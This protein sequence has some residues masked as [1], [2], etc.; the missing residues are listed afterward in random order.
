MNKI[1]GIN[2]RCKDVEEKVFKKDSIHK[3]QRNIVGDNIAEE[4]RKNYVQTQNV[5][6][7]NVKKEQENISKEYGEIISEYE[8]LI[9]GLKK[10]LQKEE[11]TKSEAEEKLEELN[12]NIENKIKSID[13]RIKA[14]NEM[15]KSI[16]DGIKANNEMKKNAE[17]YKAIIEKEIERLEKEKLISSQEHKGKIQNQESI[18]EFSNRMIEYYNASIKKLKDEKSLQENIKNIIGNEI[19]K[20]VDNY[21]DNYIKE[22]SINEENNIKLTASDK[23]VFV[24]HKMYDVLAKKINTRD[25]RLLNTHPYD[26]SNGFFNL[27]TKKIYVRYPGPHP[28]ATA[29]HEYIHYRAENNEYFEN[30]DLKQVRGGISINGGDF[31]INEALTELLTKN[32]MGNDYPKNPNCAYIDDMKNME[33]IAPIFGKKYL[34]NAYFK[35]NPNLLKNIFEINFQRYKN[36]RA[37]YELHNNEKIGKNYEGYSESGNWEEFK[38]AIE[39][40]H[41]VK[42]SQQDRDEAFRK[43]TWYAETLRVTNEYYGKKSYA[44]ELKKGFKEFENKFK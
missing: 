35:S 27:E 28:V 42:K 6:K 26:K 12:I 43:A 9:E 41:D 17:V 20:K 11:E 4:F 18:I 15:K 7:Q 37:Y 3:N 5:A 44:N 32:M 39:D 14:N 8:K 38:K 34:D 21:F 30:G 29:L 25:S 1:G 22:E 31:F 16:D 40:S 19:T 24:C 2:S 36:F 33:M 10:V 23:V 13:D